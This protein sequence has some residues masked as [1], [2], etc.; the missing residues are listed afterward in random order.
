MGRLPFAPAL[1]GF[2][3]LAACVAPPSAED[4][5]A[6]GFR[7]PEQ[8]FASFQT[9]FA[10]DQIDLEYRC[11]SR[12]FRAAQGI[13]GMTYRLAREELLK[14]Q[15]FIKWISLGDVIASERLAEDRH[16]LTV[17]VKNWVTQQRFHVDLVREDY[18]EAFVG[19][20]SAFYGFEPFTDHVFT[21]AED[22]S[23][24]VAFAQ[25]PPEVDPL[26]V[27]ELSFGR[28]WRISGFE[29]AAP[30]ATP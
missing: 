12:E 14:E 6:V 27:S 3:A 2:A 18:F 11:L 28:E 13:D 26:S 10:G 7:T 29:P 22:P 23:I 20:R 21:D 25:A 15:P 16:R 4:Y 8:A 30:P 5:L 19:G 9:A 17:E 24:L 1:I